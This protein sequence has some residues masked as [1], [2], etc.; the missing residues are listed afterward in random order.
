MTRKR[1]QRTLE[2][3]SIPVLAVLLG[4]LAASVFVIIA[5][6]SPVATYENL[7]CEGFGARGCATFGDLLF[8]Q[9]TPEDSET[10]MTVFSPFYGEGGHQ[11][12]LVLEQATP[13][14]LTALSAA[15]AFKAGMF[16]IGMDGQ[17]V[18]GAIV[19]VFLGY[20]LPDQI[21]AAVGVADWDAAPESM[22]TIMHIAIPLICMAAAMAV[23]AFYSWIAGYLKV[24]INVNVLISTIILNAIAVQLV[25]YLVNFPL[26]SDMN[27]IARTYPIDT[28][29]WLVPFNRGIFADID[30][31]SG[32]RV[33]PGIVVAL[34]AAA[35]VW[36][37]LWRTTAGY[38]Q[39]MAGGSSLFARF[40]GIPN[41]RA[42]LRAMKI[43][44]A[45]SGLAGSLVI[46]GVE[47]RVVDG[48]AM[49]GTGFD[50]VLVAI[51]SKEAVLGII[52]LAPLIAGLEV[53]SLN[54]QFGNLPRQLGGII[55]SFIILFAAMEDFLLQQITRVTRR[56]QRRQ[57]DSELAESPTG[58]VS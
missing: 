49:S 14:I 33:G 31:F 47:R 45:L 37:Y 13:L 38:E 4:L 41:D 36:V 23:G 44:G 42:A 27:N 15:V 32:G 51:L 17:F 55:I 46:L 3:I 29:A 10:A 12:A 2:G 18:L 35:L 21:Y 11:L 43:S 39:R 24:K 54:L 48:F 25:G 6:A 20:A 16:S 34:V 53:G 26:R 1:F 56:F 30:W 57:H 9:V 58:A 19:A 7:F 52:V 8:M 50:G 28:S 40:S 22:Q 5:G